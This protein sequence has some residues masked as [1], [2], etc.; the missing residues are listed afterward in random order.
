MRKETIKIDWAAY[1][2]YNAPEEF[3]P[4]VLDGLHLYYVNA[5]ENATSKMETIA[6]LAEN[7]A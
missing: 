7:L 1:P 3:A 6:I 5:F 2:Q 4:F